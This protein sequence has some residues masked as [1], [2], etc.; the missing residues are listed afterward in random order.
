MDVVLI[1]GLW[2]DG[3]SWN[4]VTE[5]L[6]HAGHS[7]HPLTLPG[8]E[9]A[10]ADRS[11]ISLA[12]HVAAVIA[13]IDVCPADRVVVVGHS[14]GCGIGYA[15]VD[16]RPERV[17]RLILVAGF[18]TG[19][20]QPL[21]EGLEGENGE[22]PF[23]GWEAFDEAERGGLDA[24]TMARMARE[25]I[26]SPARVVTDPQRLTDERRYDVPVTAISTEYDS[27]ML[28]SWI[29]A[30]AAPVAEFARMTNVEYVDLPTGHWPQLSRSAD[31]AQLI[32]NDIG[33]G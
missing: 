12:D 11:G 24:E 4:A 13:A 5:V 21:V 8:M 29:E 20:G 33:R 9:S 22:V 26:P 16:A 27:A 10:E 25:A 7:V 31:L 23:P 3:S 2:L 18:P 30:G 19:D 6:E 1:P 32:L 17:D 28:R 14:A 15:A